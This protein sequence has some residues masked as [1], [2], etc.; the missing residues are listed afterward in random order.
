MRGP[1]PM[2]SLR[3]L[4]S[5]W[6]RLAHSPERSFCAKLAEATRVSSVAKAAATLTFDRTSIHVNP[7]DVDEATPPGPASRHQI[8]EADLVDLAQVR[9]FDPAADLRRLL[10][11]G[12]DR[13][14]GV[15]VE[16]EPADRGNRELRLDEILRRA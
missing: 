2:P 10:P 1:P 4:T 5:S 7:S 11:L 6:R 16:L 8:R 3:W 14:D 9:F 12:M 15:D 13:R